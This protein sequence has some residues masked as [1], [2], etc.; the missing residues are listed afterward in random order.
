MEPTQSE[1]QKPAAPGAATAFARFA[2]CGGG[3]GLASSFA[4]TAL[5][6]HL[7]WAL[8]NALVTAL[9]T[10]LATEL[11]A[12]FTFGAGG[13]AT[14]SQHLQSAGSAAAA[15]AVTCAAMLI[16]QHLIANPGAVLEQTVYLS[17]SAFA[18][19]AR[20]AVLRLVTFARTR[21]QAAAATPCTTP[22]TVT[23]ASTPATPAALCP[24]A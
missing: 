14:V 22:A 17:A 19:T 23:R 8:A 16:L 3:I 2:L 11:H 12:R 20:F 18:G 7:P 15:Y 5:T 21:T 4:V 9:S 6:S 1:Q 13:R 24:A 10:L